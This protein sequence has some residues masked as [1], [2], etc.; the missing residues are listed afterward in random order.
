MR[1]TRAYMAGFGTAG[2]LL[3][4]ASVLFVMATAVVSYRGWPQVANAGTTPALVLPS[5]AI[6]GV[7]PTY[8]H[9]T[10]IA[11]A[12]PSAGSRARST[13]TATTRT[14]P[15]AARSLGKQAGVATL[16]LGSTGGA[17]HSSPGPSGTTTTGTTTTAPP[18]CTGAG[19]A[20]SA[21]HG[22]GGT[23]LAGVT[24]GVTGAVGAG[25]SSVGKNLGSTVSAVSGALAN[26]LSAVNP[27]VG[28][29]V[30]GTGQALGNAV[31][32]ATGTAGSAVA[33][34]GKLLSGILGGVGH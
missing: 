26:K 33:S 29:V 16:A 19:C 6:Y 18:P 7:R 23:A 14:R 1:L 11:E 4:G 17:T 2:S 20:G 21:T 13:V 10:V 12:T 34:T 32:Q 30:A 25:V 5:G 24:S 27:T 9:R 28:S 15:A 8:G 3:A 31:A 22:A